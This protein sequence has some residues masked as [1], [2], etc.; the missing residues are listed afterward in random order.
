MRTH[1][2]LERPTAEEAPEVWQEL[3][4]L[5][6]N[7]KLPVI[8]SLLTG[9]HSKGNIAVSGVRFFAIGRDE[10]EYHFVSL[11]VSNAGM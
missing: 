5:V 1:E 7:K 9:S 4:Y 11:W 8:V 3:R 2:D 6:S 10:F